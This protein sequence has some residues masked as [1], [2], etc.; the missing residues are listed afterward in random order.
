MGHLACIG[1]Q[2]TFACGASATWLKIGP[3]RY[4]QHEPPSLDAEVG[5]CYHILMPLMRRFHL[6]SLKKEDSC[7]GRL[8]TLCV[9]L[10]SQQS[11]R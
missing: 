6:A 3:N 11:Y 4:Q 9:P 5:P 7:V 8:S 2:G 1:T 10:L